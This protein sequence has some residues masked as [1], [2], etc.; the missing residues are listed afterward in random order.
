MHVYNFLVFT[1][2]IKIFKKKIKNLIS[3]IMVNIHVS[4]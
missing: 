1:N 3:Y 4:Y 2:T